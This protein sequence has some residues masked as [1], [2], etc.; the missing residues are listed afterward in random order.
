MIPDSV[1][2]FNSLW[3]GTGTVI[4]VLFSIFC[5][6]MWL[7]FTR[8]CSKPCRAM[9]LQT[10]LPERTRSLGTLCPYHCFD[11]LVGSLGMMDIT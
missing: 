5:I 11:R 10:S 6:I 8:T 2:V 7:P 1:P 3:S 9:I 4:V